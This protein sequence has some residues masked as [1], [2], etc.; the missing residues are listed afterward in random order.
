MVWVK[1]HDKLCKGAKRGLPRAVRF[2]F[3]ELCLESRPGRGVLDLPVGM[4]DLD[5]LHDVLGGSRKEIADALKLLVA[6]PKPT[7][8]DPAPRAMVELTGESGTRRLT[9]P[10]WEA[11]NSGHEVAGA[12]TER[13]RRRRQR[14]AATEDTAAQS[15]EDIDGRSGGNGD[16][17]AMQRSLHDD[18]TV[19]QREG[20]GDATQY[21]GEEI[22]EEERRITHTH[23]AS[24][25]AR[26]EEPVQDEDK[27]R[28][29]SCSEADLGALLRE[30]PALAAL[31][32]DPA[33][34]TDLH[35]G[36]VMACLDAA[37]VDLARSAIGAV[38]AAEDLRSMPIWKQRERVGRY[39]GNARKY[40]RPSDRG[41]EPARVTD[42]Q[43][44][45]LAVFGE[46]WA[47]KKRR[48]FVK[49]DGDERHAATIVEAAWDHASRL[50]MRPRDIVRHWA[51][52]YLADT[53]KFVADPEHPLRLLPSRLTSYGLP[54][55]PVPPKEPPS[56]STAP[57]EPPPPDLAASMSRPAR[58]G[59]PVR[60]P[61]GAP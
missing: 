28:P 12:S 52:R 37:T 29:P 31:A 55:K 57:L 18:A 25:P 14:Q 51:E 7:P 30:V 46:T 39:L 15:P 21:R 8:D 22:R 33:L 16:A 4:P 45:V 26:E 11:W 42:D 3:M 44:V 20:N 17:T 13:S 19:M 40:N 47:A 59:G 58:D 41:S 36:F 34:V 49:S 54:K 1:F 53:D 38:A 2:V 27:I 6:T 48:D 23:R 61:G 56:G 35:A 32:D 5:A 24:A 60:R 50:K 10:S 43:R 9:I